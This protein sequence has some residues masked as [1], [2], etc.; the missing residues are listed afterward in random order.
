MRRVLSQS[1][2]SR[3]INGLCA[4]SVSAGVMSP[5]S[6]PAAAAAAQAH[7]S[8]IRSFF[9]PTAGLWKDIRHRDGGE[10][11]RLTFEER[12]ERRIPKTKEQKRAK[13][14]ITL[15][16][17]QF[18]TSEFP[19]S[20]ERLFEK[21]QERCMMLSM[22]VLNMAKALERLEM[23]APGTAP[24]TPA[25]AKKMIILLQAA[26][27]V[28]VKPNE[29]EITPLHASMSSTILQRVS[30]FDGTL[31]VT[32][33]QQKIR[34]VMPPMTTARRDRAAAEIESTVQE[35]KQRVKHVRQGAQKSLSMIGVEDEGQLKEFFVALD[36]T[37]KQFADSKEEELMLYAEEVKSMGVEESDS[38]VSG[39]AA[40][41]AA[42]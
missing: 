12:A 26:T 30:R 32:K 7:H 3:G 29:V 37:A 14:Q 4:S 2:L 38:A 40:T 23:E 41:P 33:D 20:L 11:R 31:Q 6:S 25:A 42:Q 36:D 5:S 10:S 28:K 27:V 35:F 13:E 19:D 34:V 8:P 17:E 39:G 21:T 22:K 9:T 18:V 1:S 24:G 16:A 15:E